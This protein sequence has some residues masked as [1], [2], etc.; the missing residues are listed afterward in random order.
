[1]YISV[2]D[3]NNVARAFGYTK[4][5]LESI[6]QEAN[7]GLSCGNPVVGATLNEAHMFSR[8]HPC[9]TYS[10]LVGRS[11]SGPRIWRWHRHIFG[12]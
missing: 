7:L 4:E 2:S 11:C 6:P 5:Q 10:A 8:F 9:S 3:A 1:M 12:C